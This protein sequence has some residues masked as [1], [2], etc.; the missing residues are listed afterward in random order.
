MSLIEMVLSLGGLRFPT[1]DLSF[2]QPFDLQLDGADV[3]VRND[4]R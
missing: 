4:Q 2:R 1:I 3:T